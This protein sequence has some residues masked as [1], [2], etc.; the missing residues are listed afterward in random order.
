LATIRKTQAHNWRA[1]ADANDNW[2]K[3]VAGLYERPTHE[4][5]SWPRE[6]IYEEAVKVMVRQ[7]VRDAYDL[8][9]MES[10]ARTT[11]RSESKKDAYKALVVRYF[12]KHL[13]KD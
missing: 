9:R 11:Y 1:I 12:Q 4:V 6:A 3:S 2:C 13:N 10:M 7:I 8:K 5:R